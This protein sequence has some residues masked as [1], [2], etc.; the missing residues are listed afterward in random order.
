MHS[1]VIFDAA[2]VGIPAAPPL[3]CIPWTSPVIACCRSISEIYLFQNTCSEVVEVDV[4]DPL[5]SD[6]AGNVVHLNPNSDP[7]VS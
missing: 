3:E 5:S 2:R 7:I 6:C 1:T 4:A